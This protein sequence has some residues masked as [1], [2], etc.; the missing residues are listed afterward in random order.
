[1][2]TVWQMEDFFFWLKT[3][4]FLIL[5]LSCTEY[6]Y[7]ERK[8]LVF[9]KKKRDIHLSGCIMSSPLLLPFRLL[10]WLP[11]KL[12]NPPPKMWEE[13]PSMPPPPPLPSRRP[14]S[15]YLS[16]SSGSQDLIVLHMQN[17]FLWICHQHLDSLSGWY[18]LA[19][20][21]YAFFSL[22]S[23]APGGTPRMSV[24]F[25]VRHICHG[26]RQGSAQERRRRR[27]RSGA[28]P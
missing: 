13:I 16:H 4:Y 20:F 3:E 8:C 25:R 26:S 6:F 21:L 7:L 19:N 15:P 28:W 27:R 18:S 12:N 10:L 2:R 11:M 22:F 5:F 9:L 14:C 23:L 1:M 17:L 24:Q